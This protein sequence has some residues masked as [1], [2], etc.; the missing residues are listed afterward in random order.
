MTT[1]KNNMRRMAVATVMLV[2]VISMGGCYEAAN[3]VGGLGSLL[4]AGGDP[5][6]IWTGG[7][8]PSSTIQGVVD[9]RQDVMDRSA[10][11]WDQYITGD[12]YGGDNDDPS[13]PT[14]WASGYEWP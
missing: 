7:Y 9:Y 12:Y 6:Y 10:D 4:G 11:A 3:L 14:A 13:T 8:D 1:L 2:A 5:G